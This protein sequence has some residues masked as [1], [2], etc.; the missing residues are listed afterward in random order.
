MGIK[1]TKPINDECP[2]SLDK[3]EPN[4][5]S[6]LSCGHQY[7]NYY[8]QVFC[9]DY[10]Y[11]GKKL[12]CPLCRTQIKKKDYKKIFSNYK[13]LNQ[14][15]ENFYQ[16]NILPIQDV[17]SFKIFLKTF[18]YINETGKHIKIF[19]PL[20]SFNGINQSL[21]LQLKASKLKI[22][23]HSKLIYLNDNYKT[24][25]GEN[26]YKY[27]ICIKADSKD[28]I[29]PFLLIKLLKKLKYNM[30]DITSVDYDLKLSLKKIRLL[31]NDKDNI[32]TYDI[33]N[34]NI[35]EK[36]VIKPYS[37]LINFMPYF[38]KIDNSI[39]LINKL[40]SLMYY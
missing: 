25:Y 4:N 29:W 13:I 22:S 34:G 18:N 32:K 8:L 1:N 23:T 21:I 33:V 27:N 16:A 19:L 24:E 40:F 36:F 14:S 2:I 5:S 17:Y 6:I 9:K 35:H 10:L 15:C 28:K 12:L 11:E 3:I 7:N 38:M 30:A 20:Y 31:L 37:A 26:V 39:I